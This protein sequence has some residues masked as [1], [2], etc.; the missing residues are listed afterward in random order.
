V[1][2]REQI[3][4]RRRQWA[5]YNRWEAE[6]P[7]VERA[8]GDMIADV[9]AMWNWLAPED[10]IRDEDPEKLGIQKMRAALAHLKPRP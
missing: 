9:G 10:R 6:Q 8:A 5:E 4:E 3:E 7:P 2:L 1:T